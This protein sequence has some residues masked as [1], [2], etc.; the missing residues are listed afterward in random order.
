MEKLHHPTINNMIGFSYNNFFGDDYLTLI[1]EYASN[2]NLKEFLELKEIDDTI[3]QIIITGISRSILFQHE[4][5]LSHNDINSHK[6]LIDDKIHP[7]LSI[8][9]FIE[10]KE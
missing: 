5:N 6:I 2:G 9:T 7:H 10:Q 4:N 1:L 8:T 3:R